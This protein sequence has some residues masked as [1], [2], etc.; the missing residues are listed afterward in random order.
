MVLAQTALA[1][2]EIEAGPVRIE[3][4]DRYG[5][6]CATRL[7]PSVF[8]CNG[9][10]STEGGPGYWSADTY[11][12][13][14][15]LGV[16]VDLGLLDE[17]GVPFVDTLPDASLRYYFENV[18]VRHPVFRLLDET[19]DQAPST[20]ASSF[21]EIRPATTHGIEVDYFGPTTHNVTAAPAHHEYRIPWGQG[22]GVQYE[23]VG[24]YYALGHGSTDNFYEADPVVCNV[25]IPDCPAAYA[26]V[27]STLK[28]ATPNATIG[29]EYYELQVAGDPESLHP[30][31]WTNLSTPGPA[32][33][34][35]PPAAHLVEGL[36]RAPQSRGLPDPIHPAEPTPH[37]ADQWPNGAS[38]EVEATRSIL[39]PEGLQARN[40]AI[41][42]LAAGG[43]GLV[44]GLLIFLALYRR[45]LGKDAGSH[46][47]RESILA[48]VREQ[49]GIRLQEL[50]QATKLTHKGVDYHLHV[51]EKS[52]AV[53]VRRFGRQSRVYPN[54]GQPR[55]EHAVRISAQLS[56]P[57]SRNILSKLLATP[58][59]RRDLG[60]TVQPPVSA[61]T[62]NWHVRRLIALGL[63]AELDGQGE[64]AVT[65]A[66]AKFVEAEGPPAASPISVRAPPSEAPSR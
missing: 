39:P 66:A 44:T 31:R 43:A 41:A 29:L 48:L 7:A 45:I 21:V 59:S 6:E 9:A 8:L 12:Q 25:P 5:S 63:I 46:P 27:N 15:Y 36:K 61:T 51:L 1:G 2:A 62:L 64:L 24:P 19:D 22:D 55:D 38:E 13:I 34:S 4:E 54:G 17:S 49:P 40:R 30:T 16:S 14:R 32:S 47:V 37:S 60:A 57:I 11:Q 58:A 65:P 26:P 56:H 42:L 52:G 18:Y 53:V 28:Q 3:L 23:Q 50:A 33:S 20:P 35:A 10:A